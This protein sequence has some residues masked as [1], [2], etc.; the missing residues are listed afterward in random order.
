M[1]T[2]TAIN[3]TQHAGLERDDS[4]L[5][6][7]TLRRVTLRLIPFLFVLFVCNYLDRNNIGIAKLQMARDLTWLSESVYGF[8]AGVFFVGYSLLEVPSN[9]I[10]ARVGARRWMARIM[11]SWGIVASAMMFVRTP[12]QFYV[13]RFLLGVAEAGF[14]PGIVYYFGDWFPSRERARALA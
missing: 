5:A 10:L 11:I 4:V 8:G 7:A 1:P 13:L 2:A 6:R 3:Q 14:F 9:L 12:L